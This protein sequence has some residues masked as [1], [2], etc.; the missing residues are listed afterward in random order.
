MAGVGDRRLG[1]ESD[2]MKQ[3]A[4]EGGLN[5]RYS[6][7]ASGAQIKEGARIAMATILH[8]MFRQL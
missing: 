4:E 3:W 8:S 5:R 2:E 1:I 7:G 6:A